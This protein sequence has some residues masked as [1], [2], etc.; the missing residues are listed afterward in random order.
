MANPALF[1]PQRQTLIEI[2][3]EPRN[4]GWTILVEV[5]L[6][7][8]AA[9]VLDQLLEAVGEQPERRL[10]NAADLLGKARA[11]HGHF[12]AAELWSDASPILPQRVIGELAGSIGDEAIVCCDSGETGSA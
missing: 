10:R 7:G 2:D 8:H 11:D 6:I 1:D 9:N 4:A 12:D 5:T 3:V